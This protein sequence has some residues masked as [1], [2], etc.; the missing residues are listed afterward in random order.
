MRMICM[1]SIVSA[2][3]MINMMFWFVDAEFPPS[4]SPKICST[5]CGD[6]EFVGSADVALA[7]KWVEIP[8]IHLIL[9]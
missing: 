7:D 8:N 9:S 5:D 6:I 4:S 1:P 2:N 3:S